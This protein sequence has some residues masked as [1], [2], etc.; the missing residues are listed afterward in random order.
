M[1]PLAFGRLRVL[2]VGTR[3]RCRYSACVSI[4]TEHSPIT[5]DEVVYD[6]A[7]LSAF[8]AAIPGKGT[9]MEPT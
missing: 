3:H 2:P 8:S 7:H 6:L 9:S 4:P 5:V 1:E